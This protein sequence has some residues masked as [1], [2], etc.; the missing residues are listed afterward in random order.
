MVVIADYLPQGK[1]MNEITRLKDGKN[2]GR[3]GM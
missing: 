2:T 1:Y 3:M